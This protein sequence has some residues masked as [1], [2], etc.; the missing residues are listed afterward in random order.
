MKQFESSENPGSNE[1]RS[2][3]HE[4]EHNKLVDHQHE[5]QQ[6]GTYEEHDINDYRYAGHDLN[7]FG[8][9]SNHHQEEYLQ[10]EI[11]SLQQVPIMN[12][13]YMDAD[14]M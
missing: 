8:N 14:Q 1:R 2:Q 4:S 7:N 12:M 5:Q 3:H 9:G 13:E 11:I 10:P 6:P